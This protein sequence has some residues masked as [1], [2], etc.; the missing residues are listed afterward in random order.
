L[1]SLRS[2][3]FLLFKNEFSEPPIGVAV[4]G[5]AVAGA[6]AVACSFRNQG[7][8]VMPINNPSG[9]RKRV[10]VWP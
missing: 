10:T 2:L 6:L 5:A 9:L 3:R 7:V 4:A 1:F 8:C